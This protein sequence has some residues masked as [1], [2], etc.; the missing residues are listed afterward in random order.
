M[1][2]A[3]ERQA[4]ESGLDW[5]ETPVWWENA[6][7][8]PD[9]EHVRVHIFPATRRLRTVDGLATTGAGFVQVT[10]WTPSREGSSRLDELGSMVVDKLQ[11]KTFGIVQMRM[12]SR[13]PLAE[14]EGWARMAVTVWYE[15]ND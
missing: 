11:N 5:T 9:S 8:T 12:A 6:E 10:V 1:S 3:A 2:F 7:F 15:V 14:A 13:T 4:I